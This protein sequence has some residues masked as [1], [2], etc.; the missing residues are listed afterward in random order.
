VTM[1]SDVELMEKHG[2]EKPHILA[3]RHPH[4]PVIGV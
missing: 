4:L 1:L 3:H 2:L